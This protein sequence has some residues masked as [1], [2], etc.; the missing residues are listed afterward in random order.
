MRQLIPGASIIVGDGQQIESYG[1]Q[2]EL[3]TKCVWW[4]YLEIG[5]RIIHMDVF[6]NRSALT[7]VICEDLARVDP[8]LSLIRSLEPNLVFALLMDG[9]QLAFRWP[10]SYA[11]SLTDD[12]GSSVL[13]I[14]CAALIDRSNASRKAAGLKRGPRSIAL[15]RHHLR[16]GSAAPPNQGRHQLTLLPNQQALVLQLDSKPAPEMTVDGRANSDT[17]AWYY[18]S[19]EAIAIPRKE[20]KREGWNW[21]VDGVK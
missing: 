9:P 20:I 19:E 11:A 5:H 18:R 21:I 6:R 2:D 12:P 10:G 7:A 14:T 3:S 13:T 17:T 1:L 4:E 8:A 15:W 16:V